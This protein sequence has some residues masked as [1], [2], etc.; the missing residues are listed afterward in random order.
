MPTVSHDGLGFSSL[1]WTFKLLQSNYI[2][3]SLRHTRPLSVH[4]ID[5]HMVL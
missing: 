1:A 4:F 3:T 5:Q 2:E